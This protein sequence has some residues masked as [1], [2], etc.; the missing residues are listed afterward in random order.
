MPTPFWDEERQIFEYVKYDSQ[1]DYYNNNIKNKNED[2]DRRLNINRN[3]VEALGDIS[4][5]NFYYSYTCSYFTE[6]K[7]DEDNYSLKLVKGHTHSHYFE[8]VVNALYSF[9]ESFNISKEE[10]Q[11]YSEQQ[12]KYLRRVQKYLIIIGLKDIDSIKPSI[13]RYRNEKQ[14]KYGGSYIREYNDKT[15]DDIL[16]GKKTCFVIVSDNINIY[17]KYEEFSNHDRKELIV[18][19]DDNFKIFIEYTHCEIKTYK[20]IKNNYINE[21]LKD[22]DKVVVDYFRILQIF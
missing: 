19:N 12:L 7:L 21:K 20:E 22:D 2:F 6:E 17:K 8:D 4:S 18:D 14:K 11:F 13:K 16:S 9:P 3:I 5:I 1:L 10:E 15:I